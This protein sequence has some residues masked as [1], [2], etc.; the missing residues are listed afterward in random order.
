MQKELI[1]TLG[2][3][4][5]KQIEEA[6][7][8]KYKID[9]IVHTASGDYVPRQTMNDEIKKHSEKMEKELGLLKEQLDK[10]DTDLKDLKDKAKV[11]EEAKA[12]IDELQTKYSE[13]GKAHEVAME[14]I[15]KETQIEI[16]LIK[17]G[18]LHPELIKSLVD[19]EAV[20]EVGGKWVGIDEQIKALKDGDYK[21]QFGQ[22]VLDG[23][24]PV[25]DVRNPETTKQR[26]ALQKQYEEAQKK[27][28]T[29]TMVSLK[30]QMHEL[31]E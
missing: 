12:K 2:E 24:A 15:K 8:G 14:K 17:N 23:D 1:E 16:A 19:L 26:T 25:T 27:G 13:D 29:R 6:V 9:Q 28:D 20:K 11:G 5:V 21:D 31:K 4:L 18:A 3:E 22:V 10:R 7:K 30:G